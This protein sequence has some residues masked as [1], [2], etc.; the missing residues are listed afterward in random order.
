VKLATIKVTSA[1]SKR[2]K[3]IAQ[4][5]TDLEKTEKHL[6]SGKD[7]NPDYA[8]EEMQATKELYNKTDGR[9]YHHYI[10]SFLPGEV[11]PDQ[12][13]EIGKELAERFKGHEVLIATH[14]DKDHIHNH[15]VVNSVNYEN[16]IKLHT[17][18]QHLKEFKEYSD[19]ICQ[20]EGLSVVKGAGK[21]NLSMAELQYSARTGNASWKDQLRGYIDQAKEF[22]NNLNE[23]KNYMKEKYNVDMRIGKTITYSLRTKIEEKGKEIEK[24]LKSRDRK[25][26]SEYTKEGLENGFSR[27]QAQADSRR[28]T[29][30]GR[31]IGSD[32]KRN[33]EDSRRHGELKSVFAG[34]S[35]Q[36]EGPSD[37]CSGY[38]ES[39]QRESQRGQRKD[40][41]SI[42]QNSRSSEHDQQE[43]RTGFLDR[44]TDR[45]QEGPGRNQEFQS[46]D[47]P[48]TQD[49][50]RTIS[51]QNSDDI[52]REDKDSI[53]S[54]WNELDVPTSSVDSIWTS[55]INS[56]IEKQ[57]ENENNDKEKIKEKIKSNE[58]ER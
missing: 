49:I 33:Q 28:E 39:I 43:N 8:A 46:R 40:T 12:A 44:A 6:V 31:T 52:K 21:E 19:Q 55:Q 27:K 34:G 22:T 18:K 24:T 13:H 30:Q 38:N 35:R 11:T 15:L 57:I 7:C 2:V 25:L 58:R 50:N 26:G 3:K 9:Q 36:F 23:L 45:T 29:E 20:R 41:S 48:G 14:T 17:S 1:K 47:Y 37:Q 32:I 42:Q 56:E 5:V 16:G 54:S 51:T 10:Q 53:I 4:Y